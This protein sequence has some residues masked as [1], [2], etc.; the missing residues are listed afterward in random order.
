MRDPGSKNK[1]ASDAGGADPDSGFHTHVHTC[2][3]APPHTCTHNPESKD[4][5][6]PRIVNNDKIIIL[7]KRITKKPKCKKGSTIGC[8]CTTDVVESSI[9]G[10]KMGI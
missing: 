7:Y 2:K 10:A 5:Y 1:V 8:P 6:F 3:H 4:T 9:W